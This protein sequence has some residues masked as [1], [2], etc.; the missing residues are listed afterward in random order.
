MRK[1]TAIILIAT[2]TAFTCACSSNQA[3]TEDIIQVLDPAGDEEVK[4]AFDKAAAYLESKIDTTQMESQTDDEQEGFIYRYWTFTGE[5]E[6]LDI[7]NEIAVNGDILT[8]GQTLE[9]ELENLGYSI[10]TPADV[11]KPNEVIGISVE[12]NGKS[13]SFELKENTQSTDMPIADIPIYG[14]STMGS[15][16][17]IPFNYMGITA[18]S[19]L[20]YILSVMGSP[21]ESVN[22]STD[23]Y[24]TSF[25]LAYISNT[26][27][28]DEN[29]MQS[30]KFSFAYDQ[31]TDTSTLTSVAYNLID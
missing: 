22:M 5:E 12:D 24:V 15:E 2:V 4:E 14:F 11:A 23:S 20:E 26:Q 19:S 28:G 31:D 3:S 17:S 16:L 1:I 29:K 21:N 27:V 7:S 6:T 30:L 8:V 18:D 10:Y 25:E 9:K 13:I